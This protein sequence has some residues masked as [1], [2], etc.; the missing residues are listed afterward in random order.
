MT[1]TK[2]DLQAAAKTAGRRL[3]EAADEVLIEAG[4][5]AKDRQHRRVVNKTLKAIGKA[6]LVAGTV[7]VARAAVR[8][9]RR[10]PARMT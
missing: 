4:E 7:A 6:A 5:A 8:R 9:V 10:R 1:I 2:R 3:A